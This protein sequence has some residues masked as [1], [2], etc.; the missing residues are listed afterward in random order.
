MCTGNRV[1][2]EVGD[3]TSCP[4]VC[5]GMTNV[6]NLNHSACGKYTQKWPLDKMRSFATINI[7]KTGESDV[8]DISF[9]VTNCYILCNNNFHCVQHSGEHQ[10]FCEASDT[11]VWTPGDFCPG[12][13]SQEWSLSC[14]FHCLNTIYLSDSHL[15]QRLLISWR[16][17]L[18]L[19]QLSVYL[20]TDK[21]SCGSRKEM[22]LS[23]LYNI[24]QVRHSSEWAEL[25]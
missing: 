3:D 13:Q 2:P 10:F 17:T 22:S 7:S 4:V 11:P 20:H 12:F 16:S 23:L 14:K 5:D 19:S 15:V 24:W 9:I 1:K 25:C 21:H 6:P 8:S 18:Q